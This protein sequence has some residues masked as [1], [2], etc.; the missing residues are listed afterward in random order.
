ML[1]KIPQTLYTVKQQNLQKILIKKKKK[2]CKINKMIFF[3]LG[4]FSLTFMIQRTAR[5]VWM[6]FLEFLFTTSIHYRELTSSHNWQ[7]YSN[8]KHLI[9]EHKSLTTKLPALTYKGCV[10][11]YNVE[12]LNSFYPE[13]QLKDSN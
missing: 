13:R 8:Q 1:A 10:S 4:F 6:V 2:K 5:E 9:F 11:T 12:I 7:Q 3:H